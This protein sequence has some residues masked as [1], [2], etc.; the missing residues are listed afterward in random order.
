MLWSAT[1]Y[2]LE[3]IFSGAGN[4]SKRRYFKLKNKN[5]KLNKNLSL[6]KSPFLI[7]CWKEET[8]QFAQKKFTTLRL[9]CTDLETQWK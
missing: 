4:C 7:L 1:N 5:N 2:K 8:E 3:N 9:A 6:F